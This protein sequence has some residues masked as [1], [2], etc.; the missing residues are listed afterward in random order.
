MTIDTKRLHRDGDEAFAP[1]R[2][3][4]RL[5]NALAARA[6]LPSRAALP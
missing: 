1:L 3:R 2:E 5:A 4:V 6:K